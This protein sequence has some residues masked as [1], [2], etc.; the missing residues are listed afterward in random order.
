MRKGLVTALTRP[1]RS[2]ASELQREHAGVG[3]MPA[4][5]QRASHAHSVDDLGVRDPASTAW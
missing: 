3:Q 1:A 5:H 2:L 4:P